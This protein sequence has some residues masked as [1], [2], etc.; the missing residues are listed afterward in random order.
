MQR[1]IPFLILVIAFSS[2]RKDIVGGP[3]PSSRV[4]LSN[5]KVGQQSR[6]LHYESTCENLNGDF[7]FTNDTL[8]VTVIEKDNELHLEERFTEHSPSYLE[9]GIV[10]AWDYRIQDIGD[11]LLIPDRF[12]SSLF[13]FYG[14]DTL[15]L[16]HSNQVDLV[17]NS[18]RLQQ[19]ADPFIGNDIGRVGIFEFGSVKV[20]NCMAASCVPMILGI[21]GYLFYSGQQLLMSQT[22]SNSIGPEPTEVSGWILQ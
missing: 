1:I 13:Y 10:E 9:D 7:H 21:D 8:L 11:Q 2:C 3:Q 14:N 6:Y 20:G 4:N 17:Q 19:D 15:R 22:V 16:K 18:C 12:Q 5:P